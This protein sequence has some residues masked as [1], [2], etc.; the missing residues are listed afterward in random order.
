MYLE[1]HDEHRGTVTEIELHLLRAWEVAASALPLPTQATVRSRDSSVGI[2]KGWPRIHGSILYGGMRFPLL[3]SVQTGL[4]SKPYPGIFLRLK[5]TTRFPL[6]SEVLWLAASL[7][8]HG[9]K[10]A[11][12]R[13]V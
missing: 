11:T 8:K 3:H 9:D 10:L 5:L 13:P 12:A 1:D 2:G 6:E 7:A 4:L